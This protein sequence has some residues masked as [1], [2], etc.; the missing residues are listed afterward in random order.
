MLV[1]VAGGK[2]ENL[3]RTL[4][5]VE[6]QRKLNLHMALGWNQTQPTLLVECS[7]HCAIPAV[8]IPN[9]FLIL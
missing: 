9:K 3:E 8:Q 6:R 1:F 7:D 4:E 2:L 5:Q